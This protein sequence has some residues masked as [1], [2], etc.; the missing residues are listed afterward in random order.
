M[1]GCNPAVGCWDVPH[2]PNVQFFTPQGDAFHGTY[3]HHMEGKA[4]L[5][6]G[7]VNLT[8]DDAAWLYG[9]TVVGTDVIII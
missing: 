2:V 9:W 1:T 5:S 7:C 6:H 3:W 4:N 8:L